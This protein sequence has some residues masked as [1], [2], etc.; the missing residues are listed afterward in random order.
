MFLHSMSIAHRDIKLDNIVVSQDLTE[1]KFI[2]FGLCIDFSKC[3]NQKTKQFCGTI[4]YMPPEILQK[5]SY[6][7]KKADIWS[8]GVLLYRILY[9]RY[10]YTGKDEFLLL[11]KMRKS[12]IT[13]SEDCDPNLVKLF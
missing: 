4:Q 12:K 9:N 5:K 2:D 7:P 10:P 11:E 3:E 8:L 6:N 1:I 13:L